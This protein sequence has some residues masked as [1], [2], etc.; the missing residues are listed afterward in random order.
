MEKRFLCSDGRGGRLQVDDITY[1]VFLLHVS[2]RSIAGQPW[3]SRP[4]VQW[5]N[6]NNC[7]NR[8]FDHE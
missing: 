4:V 3:G 8:G 2:E 6:A 5:M 7:D 1:E